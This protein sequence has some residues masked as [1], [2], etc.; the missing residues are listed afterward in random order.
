MDIVPNPPKAFRILV[1]DDEPSL[2]S[3]VS[4]VLLEDGNEVTTA[5]SAEEALEMFRQ[6]PFPLIVT[7]IV[8]NKMSGIELLHEI[9]K[10]NPDTE[11]IIMTSHASLDS[12]ITALRNG[13]YDYLTKPFDD[14]SLISQTVGRVLEKIRLKEE[15]SALLE[16]LRQKNVELEHHNILLKDMAIRDG[17]TGLFNHRHFQE[18]LAIE[19]V[20]AKRYK[21]SL[22]LIFVDVDSFKQ[23]NDSH[24]HPEGDKVLVT[25]ANLF[26]ESLRMSDTIARYGGEEFVLLLPETTKEGALRVAEHIRQ[27]VFDYPFPHRETQPFGRVTISLGVA[28]FPDDGEDGSSLIK[29][30][31]KA[32]YQAK[33]LGRNR[34]C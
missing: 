15:N 21:R 20:R 2:R 17:L 3:V 4:Q 7:D 28:T 1:V 6:Q 8:M 29:R 33:E 30:A 11:V 10:K 14:I 16:T 31:D 12:A 24:G 25:L 26:P 19:L 27:N 9:K 34:V 13:A 18:A 23:Y 22:S 5:A 32:L